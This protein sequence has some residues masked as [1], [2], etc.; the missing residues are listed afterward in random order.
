MGYRVLV[1]VDSKLARMAVAKVL[2]ALHPDWARVEAANA[3]ESLA[4]AKK[5]DRY[6]PDKTWTRTNDAWVK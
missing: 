3:D 2:T 5:I 1:V 4:L 6:N